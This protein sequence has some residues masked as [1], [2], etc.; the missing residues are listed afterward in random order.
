MYSSC[1]NYS[2]KDI[3]VFIAMYCETFTENYMYNMVVLHYAINFYAIV[4]LTFF[5]LFLLRYSPRE[6][7]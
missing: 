7:K 4:R 5:S 1:L 2:N 6:K 3:T